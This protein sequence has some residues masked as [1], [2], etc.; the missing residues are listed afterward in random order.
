M[1]TK[2]EKRKMVIVYGNCH[3]LVISK[4]L[5]SSPSFNESYYIY[6][7]KR[8]QDI[9]DTSYLYSDFFNQCD[10][11]IH[12]SIRLNNRYGE[13]FASEKIIER[14]KPSCQVI[15]IPNVYHLPTCFFP[16]YSEEKELRTEQL[17]TYFFRDRILDK[18]IYHPFS[19]ITSAKKDYQ[20]EDLFDNNAIREE[21][22]K[23]I[24]K[25]RKR[26]EDWDIKVA[27]YIMA[28]YQDYKMFYDPNHPTNRFLEYISNKLLNILL[29]RP[30][31]A[32]EK[33]SS[34]ICLDA[35]EMPVCKATIKA[36][37]L[38]WHDTLLR[39][40][41]PHTNLAPICMNFTYYAI[42]YYALYW[43]IDPKIGG[44]MSKMIFYLLKPVVFVRR[45][46]RK[47]RRMFLSRINIHDS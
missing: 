20:S 6:N 25:V 21:F 15:S 41:Y 13:E 17:G 8:I 7:I 24:A 45:V 1:E 28:N 46:I 3:T 42:T 14:L 44:G 37:N 19:L 30:A 32:V 12:Q 38:K 4:M 5:E 10:V 16:Q 29:E 39:T 9:K 2:T 31:D 22:D 40:S 43:I 26:E 36:L 11:F 35:I 18:Y 33:L 34:D 47:L 23:F 27:D